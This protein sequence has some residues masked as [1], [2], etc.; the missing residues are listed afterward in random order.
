M[1]KEINQIRSFSNAL[2]VICVIALVILF[3]GALGLF[4]AVFMSGNAEFIA[5]LK[6]NG[7]DVVLGGYMQILPLYIVYALLTVVL[8][9]VVLFMLR[10]VLRNIKALA[11]FNAENAKRLDAIA[12]ILI[13]GAFLLPLV[14]TIGSLAM[15]GRLTYNLSL[16]D[17]ILGLALLLVS[18]IL[19]Y[20]HA[21][22]QTEIKK[23]YEEGSLSA[24]DVFK[25]N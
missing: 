25:E 21:E 17:I 4:I 19:L 12:Y 2:N 7:Y 13:I 22:A 1:Q 14:L 5:M 8:Y 24:D 9:I 6:Q 3:I 11:I 20:G 23:R 18:R 10:K 15:L 16:T